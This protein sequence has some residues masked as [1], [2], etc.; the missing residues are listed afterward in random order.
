MQLDSWQK[1][2]LETKGHIL[3][4][5][6]RQVGK[7]TIF[8]AKAAERMAN[9]NRCSIVAVSLT[10]DQAFLMRFMVEDYLKKHY[11]SL[12]K[13]PKK[14]KPTKNKIVLSNGSSYVVR[15]VGNT[16]DSV[17]GFTANVLIV[18]E[19]AYMPELMW[20]AAKPT[21]LT[22]GGEVWMCS[23]PHGKEGYFYECFQNKNDYFSVF[24]ISSEEVITN[25]EISESWT[26]EKRE[27]AIRIL[28]EEKN[29]MSEMQYA[30]EYLGQFIDELRRFFSEEWIEKVC[31]I[32]KEQIEPRLHDQDYYL[33]VDIARLG[34]DEC[35][36]EIIRKI[37]KDCYRH[38]YHETQKNW[39]TTKTEAR[40]VEL[41]NL[42]DAKKAYI[43]AGAG[44][45]GVG[46]LDHLLQLD[47]IK[48]KVEAVNNRQIITDRTGKKKQ[49][50][51]K[52]DLYDN[53][54]A[55]G[56]QGK[57]TLFNDEQVMLSL[58]SVQYEY[59]M[60]ANQKSSLRIFGNYTHIAE[61]LI[62]AAV[63]SKEKNIK[64][65]ISTIKI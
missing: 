52:E 29:Q 5:T 55:L 32:K 28:E 63:C 14:N 37:N 44:S 16:G 6:G 25:R 13:V 1:E 17:R 41:V 48:R 4:C 51:L 21:L 18:D 62:R 50:L 10:E 27:A 47:S 46:I 39:I 15:P 59:V 20:I 60:K 54:R 35:A 38:V 31:T 65:F 3:L 36:F 34:G 8:A 30:Q 61:G 11:P 26:K 9:Q 45:L 53:L 58:R 33:G 56:E 19:A 22:T 7:T 23:T 49:R 64:L 2:I 12:L 24:H 43:D 57:L 42:Y 40:I